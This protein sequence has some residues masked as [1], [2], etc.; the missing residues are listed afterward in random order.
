MDRSELEAQART[1]PAGQPAAG[2]GGLEREGVQLCC[3]VLDRLPFPVVLGLLLSRHCTN[4]PGPCAGKGGVDDA[5]ERRA[6]GRVHSS[7]YLLGNGEAAGLPEP[8]HR[9]NDVALFQRHHSAA[10][11]GLRSG[12]SVPGHRGRGFPERGVAC[13][14]SLLPMAAA[15]TGTRT[16]TG[17][18]L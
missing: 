12:A 6:A 15:T 16:M 13:P 4:S 1:N 7:H 18:L 8:Q 10:H 14:Y 9:G 11:R 2:C 3:A 17:L 5:I